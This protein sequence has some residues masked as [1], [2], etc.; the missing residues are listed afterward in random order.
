MLTVAALLT[1]AGCASPQS[2][3][4]LPPAAIAGS[5]SSPVGSNAAQ[6]ADAAR[7]KAFESTFDELA[8]CNR[9]NGTLESFPNSR[10]AWRVRYFVRYQEMPCDED[11]TEE[12]AYVFHM[13]TNDLANDGDLNAGERLAIRAAMFDNTIHCKT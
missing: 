11:P 5:G 7:C 4:S 2:G 10:I 13:V 6:S 12:E 8:A 1:G 3:S 9:A